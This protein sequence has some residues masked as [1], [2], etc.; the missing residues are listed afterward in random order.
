MFRLSLS[1]VAGLSLFA[2]QQGPAVKLVVAKP[3]LLELFVMSQCP[4][5]TQVMDAVAPVVEKLGA[6][7]DLKVNY[8][9]DKQGETLSSMH[10]DAEVKG[11]IVQLCAQQQAPWTFLK[12]VTCQNK[13]AREVATNWE[14]CAKD[15]GLDV[16]Q[17]KSCYEGDAGKKLLE[18]S[19]A[20]AKTR[21]AEGSPTMFLNGQPYNGGRKTADF[22]KAICAGYGD[23][24]KP[25]ACSNIPVAPKVVATFFSDHRCADCNIDR[26]EGRLKSDIGGAEVKKVDYMSDEGKKLY[27]EIKAKDP[28]FKGLPV[29]LLDA[30][31]KNDSDGMAAIGRY[32]RPLGDSFMLGLNGSFDPTAEI[33][34]NKVDDDQNS[35]TDCDDAP[36]KEA[37]ACRPEKAKTLEAFVMSQCPYGAKAMA[38]MKE[39]LGTFSKDMSFNVHFIG[40]ANGDAL[41]SMHGS[42]EVDEDLRQVCAVKHY[43]KGLKYMD[44]IGCRAADYQSTNWQACTGNNGIDAKVIDK[45]VSGEGKD[46]LKKDFVYSSLLKMDASPTFLANNRY[47]FGGVDA[48]S[49]KQ[50][51]CKYN[52]GLPGC[53]KTLSQDQAVQGS[54]GQQ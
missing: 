45:C 23:G 34:D 38:A 46:L 39:V 53:G 24:T 54:C 18:E 52:S 28:S 30:N 3:A 1:F 10:G 31:L 29:I 26:L 17:L 5:G 6:N 44:Y 16:L 7:L 42:A 49:I 9:G 36:C 19:F 51:Y 15:A 50:N 21:G 43:N 25:E 32:V 13:N 12:M 41:K 33:C 22:I 4:Y 27:A 2:C 48:E 8:I 47:S 35:K 40:D 37:M 20:L 14:G 11:D